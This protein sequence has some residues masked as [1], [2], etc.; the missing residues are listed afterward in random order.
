MGKVWLG[1][2]NINDSSGS[3]LVAIADTRD[4]AE[5]AIYREWCKHVYPGFAKENNVLDFTS[6]RDWNGAAVHLVPVNSKYALVWE[7][8]K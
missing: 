8:C 5:S 4:Q 7:Q 6:L 2:C 1:I 3:T